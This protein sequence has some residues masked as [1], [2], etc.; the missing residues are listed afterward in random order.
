MRARRKVWAAE[1]ERARRAGGESGAG[2]AGRAAGGA[3][4][5]GEGRSG[6]G[7]AAGRE[8]RCL[9]PLPASPWPGGGRDLVPRGEG[10]G[11]PGSC[12]PPG[13]ERA[14]RGAARERAA[15]RFSPAGG[16]AGGPFGR[17][18]YGVGTGRG[19]AQKRGSERLGSDPRSL[20]IPS[21]D[22]EQTG[23][24]G[25]FF[26]GIR[27]FGELLPSPDSV[28]GLAP[29]VE[30]SDT[31]KTC[32]PQ[33]AFPS[34]LLTRVA[35]SLFTTPSPQAPT[36]FGVQRGPRRPVYLP[37]PLVAGMRIVLPP[38]TL[39]LGFEAPGHSCLDQEFPLRCS[40]LIRV[41]LWAGERRDW[42]A[43]RKE[44]LEES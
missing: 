20:G 13:P 32:D 29:R 15:L 31:S 10:P 25:I 41:E 4:A 3:Q 22:W 6:A 21:L 18:W 30:A 2:G 17:G 38:F 28:G 23:D 7:A 35:S 8:R 36:I 14:G 11:S 5:G 43:G 19:R 1:A 9:R 34:H 39:G 24:S 44:S 12:P 40:T 42:E 16:T 33:W 37:H 27:E 26:P